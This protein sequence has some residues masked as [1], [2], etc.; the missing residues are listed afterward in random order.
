MNRMVN[1]PKTKQQLTQINTVG[2][3]NTLFSARTEFDLSLRTF[4]ED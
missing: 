4:D 1:W 3:I 2:N